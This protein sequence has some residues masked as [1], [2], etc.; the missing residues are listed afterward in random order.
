MTFIT[1]FTSFDHINN[2]IIF[3]NGMC[4][5]WILHELF[6]RSKFTILNTKLS[7]IQD[8]I[9]ELITKSQEIPATNLLPVSL[10]RSTSMSTSMLQSHT[11]SPYKVVYKTSAHLVR[12]DDTNNTNDTTNKTNTGTE[13]VNK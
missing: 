10:S 6:T 4:L 13:N 8:T 12:T 9:Q 11:Q 1:Y 3:V 7:S 2:V 5:G